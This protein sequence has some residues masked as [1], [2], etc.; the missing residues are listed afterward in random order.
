MT[1][2][3]KRLKRLKADLKLLTRKKLKR[4][5]SDSRAFSSPDTSTSGPDEVWDTW[6][7]SRSE[8]ESIPNFRDLVTEVESRRNE[9][10]AYVEQLTSLTNE[11]SGLI[12][13][14]LRASNRPQIDRA[15]SDLDIK[16]NQLR[17]QLGLR[18][19]NSLSVQGH[20]EIYEHAQ[21]VY[22][23]A[24]SEMESDVHQ[25]PQ[26]RSKFGGV[27]LSRHLAYNPYL[28]DRDPDDNVDWNPLPPDDAGWLNQR[29]PRM[30]FIAETGDQRRARL[31]EARRRR[32][33]IVAN[34]IQRHRIA[35]NSRKHVRRWRF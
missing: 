19:R 1:E 25:P 21:G 28:N 15:L 35:D 27:A 12:N 17:Q 20:R 5:L 11:T 31:E 3:K 29:I 34:V 4:V 23:Q 32:E 30:P 22:D 9:D 10:D 2:N 24:V 8:G 7:D 18:N 33:D 16:A 26:K 13:R 6:S 14:L